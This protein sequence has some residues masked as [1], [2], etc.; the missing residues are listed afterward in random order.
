MP[1]HH[2]IHG[3]FL[4][5][6]L[7]SSNDHRDA[8]AR[9]KQT[10]RNTIVCTNPDECVDI[11]TDII[12]EKVI[13]IISTDFAQ[14]IISLIDCLVQVYSIYESLHRSHAGSYRGLLNYILR[15]F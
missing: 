13:L 14:S 8:L 15:F 10:V 7:T 3:N 5:V 6:W 1:D 11:L 2:S 12:H 9:M 4:L